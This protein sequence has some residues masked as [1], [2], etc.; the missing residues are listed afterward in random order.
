M[1]RSASAASRVVT[2]VLGVALVVQFV[3]SLTSGV[4]FLGPTVD[5]TDVAGVIA[6]VRANP[7]RA[8]LGIGIDVVTALVIACLSVLFAM[9]LR[10]VGETASRIAAALYV[11]EACLLLTSKVL[12]HGF[13]AGVETGAPDS[14]LA[15]WLSATTFAYGLHMVAF[16]AGACLFYALLVRSN[17][18]PRWMS[19]WGLVTVV[20]VA[21]GT[22]ASLVGVN[23]PF[24]V[25]LP[26]APFEL[27]AGIWLVVSTIR[28]R[29]AT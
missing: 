22:V 27:V 12:A 19:W 21:L 6:A 3:T 23:V 8:H 1:S 10:T 11:V 25:M 15:P 26:Y 9:A 2:I 5:T 17:L 20:P 14:A 13:V 16:S 4:L 24:W 18:L 28:G 7:G 29:R